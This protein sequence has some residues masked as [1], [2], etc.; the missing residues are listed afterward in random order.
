MLVLGNGL[1][2]LVVW[3]TGNGGQAATFSWQPHQPPTFPTHPLRPSESQLERQL[4]MLEAC[5]RLSADSIDADLGAS[6]LPAVVNK[7]C[8]RQLYELGA[9]GFEN[10][11]A[12][13]GLCL[14]TEAPQ[15]LR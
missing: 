14:V 10:L 2:D 7:A 5:R 3:A 11:F 13:W 8:C 1:W 6:S 12:V 9:N 15:G 4:A